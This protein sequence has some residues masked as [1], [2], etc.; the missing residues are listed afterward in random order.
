[1]GLGLALILGRAVVLS[2]KRSQETFQK[3]GLGQM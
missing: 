1:L 3:K 2:E